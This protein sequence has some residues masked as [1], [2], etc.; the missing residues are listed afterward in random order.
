M[1]S[2]FNK[3]MLLLILALTLCLSMTACY[4]ANGE[5]P[6]TSNGTPTLSSGDASQS[7]PED[8]P[9]T[10]EELDA[11]CKEL[12]T[13]NDGRTYSGIVS[14][15]CVIES[16][17]AFIASIEKESSWGT[18][19]SVTIGNYNFCGYTGHTDSEEILVYDGV[20]VK[21]LYNAYP[22][23]ISEKD[24]EAVYYKWIEYRMLREYE[25]DLSEKYELLGLQKAVENDSVIVYAVKV[26]LKD[27][28]ES[29]AETVTVGDCEFKD[30]GKNAF[31]YYYTKVGIG[32]GVGQLERLYGSADKLGDELSLLHEYWN[33]NFAS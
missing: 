13:L 31:L 3:R 30:H 23:G 26:A 9:P 20:S 27:G 19:Q 7:S 28:A 1:K 18:A 17:H 29:D 22:N 10:L 25:E 8:S 4:T 15:L 14:Y 33:V 11:A 2:N 5:E 16:G 32:Y 12:L 6:G 21:A 24:L